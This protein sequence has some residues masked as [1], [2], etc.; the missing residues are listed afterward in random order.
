MRRGF[1]LIELLVVI[2]IIAI[3][4]AILFPV[5][6]RARE[7]ARQSS[8]TSNL[9]QLGTA[10]MMYA[11][12]YD[13][14]LMDTLMGRDTGTDKSRWFAWNATLMPYVANGQVFVCPSAR[15]WTSPNVAVGGMIM[16]GYG[17][18][19]E[20]LGY[21]GGLDYRAA[22]WGTDANKDA[23]GYGQPIA[24][25]DAPAENIV[26]IDSTYWVC[27]RGYWERTD[28]ATTPTAALATKYNNA[29][30]TVDSRHNGQA[31]AAFADGH[32]KSLP[33]GLQAVPRAHANP[34]AGAGPWRY[35]HFH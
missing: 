25:M 14:M 4:A 20:V 8:C 32:V 13:E 29:Y 6:A 19:R 9:K 11:Q 16:G 34:M 18:V 7:K 2:A 17:A 23:P 21:A 27:Q 24:M 15:G 12:D 26:I 33:Q 5:F 35:Y 31:N 28:N 10:L 3:L 22:D 30:Y 1:T